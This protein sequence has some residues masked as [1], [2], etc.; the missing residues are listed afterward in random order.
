MM[1]SNCFRTCFGLVG[2]YLDFLVPA[3]E[4]RTKRRRYSQ[5]EP[6]LLPMEE[7]QF[8]CFDFFF[9]YSVRFCIQRI[10]EGDNI[11]WCHFFFCKYSNDKSLEFVYAI[12]NWLFLSIL[13]QTSR[14]RDCILKLVSLKS[15]SYPLRMHCA[16]PISYKK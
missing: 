4:K 7:Q 10:V 14:G 1:Y 9:H 2:I 11:A 15:I 6:V 13:S 16:Y 3:E 5:N 8:H 12:M